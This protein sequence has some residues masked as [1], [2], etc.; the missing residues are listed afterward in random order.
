MRCHFYYLLFIL[1]LA[2]ASLF[3]VQAWHKVFVYTFCCGTDISDDFYL[4]IAGGRNTSAN[5][6]LV[7]DTV[8]VFLESVF[9]VCLSDQ[10][11]C[12]IGQIGLVYVAQ[13]NKHRKHVLMDLKQPVHTT[14]T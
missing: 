5:P 9:F 13:L 12:G 2:A 7:N 6:L 8:R 1:Y 14:L 10:P 11:L 3:K 4:L